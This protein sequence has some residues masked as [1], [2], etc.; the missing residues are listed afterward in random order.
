MPGGTDIFYR[1][2]ER[3]RAA[4]SGRAASWISPPSRIRQFAADG[5]AQAGAA[6]F[7]ARAGVGLLEGLKDDLLL[8]GG[9]PMPVSVTSKATTAAPAEHRMFLAP[10]AVAAESISCT[11][12]FSVNLNALES[13]FLSTC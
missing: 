8:V 7:A 4:L 6:I 2:I 12:P 3:E 11:P 1:Q 5:K 13:R 10:P 9:M